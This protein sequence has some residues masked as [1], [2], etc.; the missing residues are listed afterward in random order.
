MWFDHSVTGH[1]GG[2]SISLEFPEMADA[3]RVV[4]EGVA[5]LDALL[6]ELSGTVE[7]A[8]AGFRGQAATGLGEALDAWFGVAGTLGPILEGY[9]QALMTVANEHVRNEAEQTEHYQQLADRLGGGS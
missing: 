9:A 3:A 1:H 2:V 6:T 4:A 8:A 7:T 5:P